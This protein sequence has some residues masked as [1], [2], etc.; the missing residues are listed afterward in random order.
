[1]CTC[2][3]CVC[4]SRG[5]AHTYMQMTRLHTFDMSTPLREC[6]HMYERGRGNVQHDKRIYGG[7]R[8][9]AQKR[10]KTHILMLSVVSSNCQKKIKNQGQPWKL[11][12][13]TDQVL[14]DTQVCGE[15]P[16]RCL[17]Q[18]RA[19]QVRLSELLH[20]SEIEINTNFF[21]KWILWVCVGVCMCVCSVCV[22][23]FFLF[24]ICGSVVRLLKGKKDTLQ[25]NESCFVSL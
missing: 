4:V 20:I 19:Q 10:A 15:I 21:R 24:C 13:R 6:S 8:V 12:L 23:C 7:L 22:L 18:N 9:H 5:G 14:F 3:V 17:G 25:H 16:Q 2:L 11:M 1:M